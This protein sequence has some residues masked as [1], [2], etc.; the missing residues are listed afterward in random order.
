MPKVA[1][2]GSA[3]NCQRQDLSVPSLDSRSRVRKNAD[4][5]VAL[6][7]AFARTRFLGRL[8]FQ[9]DSLPRSH[10]RRERGFFPSAR[11]PSRSRVRKNAEVCVFPVAAFAKNADQGSAVSFSPAPLLVATF[12]ENVDLSP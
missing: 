8:F 4:V 3:R 10:V 11:R 2:L 9:P 5:C 12:A 7:A 6:V 1:A